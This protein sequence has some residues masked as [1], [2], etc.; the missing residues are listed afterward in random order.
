MILFTQ[1]QFFWI[2]SIVASV[3]QV[4]LIIGAF[5]NHGTPVETGLKGWGKNTFV[6]VTI[7]FCTGFGWGGVMA[8]RQELPPTATL[9]IAFSS[10]VMFTVLMFVM[11]RFLI[12]RTEN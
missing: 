8:L 11:L 5:I 12:E 9:V 3:F 6:R 1:P 4:S 2:V 7:S 10:A